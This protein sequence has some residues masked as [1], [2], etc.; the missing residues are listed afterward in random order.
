MEITI[1]EKEVDDQSESFTN[2][3]DSS[4]SPS[5]PLRLAPLQMNISIPKRIFQTHKSVEYIRSKPQLQ[6]AINS[7]RRYVP[8][9]GYHFYT[10]EMCDEFMKT[11]MVELFGEG[12]YEAYNKLPMEVMKADLWRYCVIYKFGGIYADADTICQCNPNIFTMYDT[13]LVCAPENSEHLCQWCFAAPANSPILKS[14]IELSIERILEMPVIKGEHII[15]FLTGPAVFS[16]G[17]ENYLKENNCQIFKN[18]QQYFVYKNPTMICFKSQM[19]HNNMI[20]HLFL[21]SQNDGWKRERFEK[22]M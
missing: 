6:N 11:D 2:V 9:F 7:W 15:H 21:G 16:D 20:Q 8:E 14:V 13:M 19:F 22:L 10:N 18:R 12:I 5:L 4:R 17:V 3:T 1:T